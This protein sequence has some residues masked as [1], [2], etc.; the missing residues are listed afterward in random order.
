MTPTTH[1]APRRRPRAR[2]SARLA[3]VLWLAATTACD[4][5]VDRLLSA[6]TPSRLPEAGFLVPENAALIVNSAVADFECAF[7]A[8]V[9]TSG[10]AAGELADV[11]Q[12]ATRWNYDRRNVASIDAHYSTFNCENLGIYTPVSTARYTA[13]Q[14][15]AQLD[16][17]TDAQVADRSRLIARAALYSGYSYMLLA[18]G[19]CTAAVNLG[20]ELNTTQLLDSAES[21]FTRA[22]TLATAPADSLVR[23]A[24]YVGR[25]RARIGKGDRTGAAA[26]AAPAN[27][28][29]TF[30]LLATSGDNAVRRQN[31]VF[32]QN[33]NTSSG[34]SVAPSYRRLTVGGVPDTRVRADSFGVAGDQLNTVW[35][36]SKYASLTAGIPIASGFEARLIE[37]EALGAGP[38][39]AILNDLRTRRSLPTL[40]AAEQADFTATLFEERRREL[41]LQGN[42]WFDV[43]RA[44]LPLVPATGAAYL[45]GGSYGDQRCWPMPDVEIAANPNI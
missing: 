10:L 19:F 38:G 35:R 27:V 30:V 1:T 6:E 18:E 33:N 7:G 12:T 16:Q 43:R 44:N 5:T 28:P 25:A 24:A 22:I 4:S 20:P 2:R 31:R 23:R 42:R 11:S 37:A 14:A 41:F 8:Y 21:R 40:S 9:V 36:Q 17:W 29:T 45:K 39:V 3:L 15:I 13:D 32:A 26:D 34:V